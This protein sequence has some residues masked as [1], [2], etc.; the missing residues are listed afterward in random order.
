MDRPLDP[1]VRKRRIL[2]SAA[3]A[4]AAFSVVAVLVG[5]A[6]RWIRPSLS[7]ADIR[8]ATVD[9]GP[10]EAT[11]SASG[12]VVPEFEKV[13]A[14]PLDARV[15]KI[16]R[17]PGALLR[18]G[19]PIL[20][21]DVAES[22]L[23][24]E[25]LKQEISLKAN[26]QALRRLELENTLITLRSQH[27]LK[28]VDVKSFGVQ[29][30]KQQKLRAAGLNTE[31][32]LRQAQVDEEKAAIELKQLEESIRAAER[33]TRA[34]LEGL[35]LELGTLE[36]ET[37]QSR[38]QLEMATTKSDRDGVLTWVVQ[39]EGALVRKGD[40]LAR[41][42]DLSSFRVEA[43]ISDIHSARLHPGLRAKITV[44]E[45]ESLEGTVSNVLPTIKDGVVSAHIA[46]DD[47]SNPLLRSNLRVDVF[48]VTARKQRALRLRRGAFA[49][50]EGVHD[51]FVIRGE[52]AVRV[53][54]RLGIASF[55]HA[56]VVEGLLEGDEVI[57]SDM[58]D[59]LYLKEVKVNR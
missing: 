44:N 2:R 19:E 9:S 6:P 59:Y 18:K 22:Q 11:F 40:V 43:T 3:G 27:Q 55:E 24:L 48:I 15:I 56:E 36:K 47:K 33:N 17:K 57:I 21:L 26:Q 53:P 46:L 49:A 4:A 29:V 5:W 25:K 37:E 7:R 10:V 50:D 28:A 42:A 20:D 32:Q 34:Q 16:L 13:L 52:K 35:A 8:T 31:E 54:V 39:E 38:R 14:S 41:I 51:L 23:A 30:S 1:L 58:K 12:T 45:N